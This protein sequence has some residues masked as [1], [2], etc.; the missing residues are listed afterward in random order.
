VLLQTFAAYQGHAVEKAETNDTL[1]DNSRRRTH[2]I[3]AIASSNAN[4]ILRDPQ[5]PTSFNPS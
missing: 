2:S 4:E 5:N 1:S 3:T